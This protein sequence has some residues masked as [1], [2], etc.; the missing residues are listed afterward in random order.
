MGLN[1]KGLNRFKIGQNLLRNA[2]VVPAEK[3]HRLVTLPKKT[4]NININKINKQ[5]QIKLI[6]KIWK[7]N[8]EAYLDSPE[9]S[10]K[11]LNFKTLVHIFKKLLQTCHSL[12]L[13]MV[14]NVTRN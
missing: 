9:F 6:Q 11:R 14:T 2:N 12:D 8:F 13:V 3:Q 10:G 4:E 5:T 1:Q 7:S